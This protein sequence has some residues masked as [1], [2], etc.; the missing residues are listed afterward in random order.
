MTA[1][2]RRLAVLALV[3]ALLLAV[4]LGKGRRGDVASAAASASPASGAVTSVLARVMATPASAGEAPARPA[5]LPAAM[6]ERSALMQRMKADW[7]G[8]GAAEH[9][10]QTEGV[11]ER[12]QAKNGMVGTEAIEEAKQTPGAEVMEE[13]TGQVRR[14]WVRA[15]MQ[16]GDPR[17]LAVADFLGGLDEDAGAARV[18][19]QALARTTSDPMVTALALQRPCEGGGCR[20]VEASQWSRL[21]PANLQ[22]WLTLLRDAKGGASSSQVSYALDRMAAEGRYSRSYEREFRAVLLSLPQTE[23]PG[24]VNEAE[25]QLITG[26]AAAWA[27]ASY[28]P[29]TEACLAASASGLLRCETVLDRLWEGD[30]QMD[31]AIALGMARRL[32]LP[33]H[34]EQRARW[35]PRAREYE[36]VSAW[37][38]SALEKLVAKAESPCSP[39]TE[40]RRWI[41]GT[42]QLGEW[43]QWR[44]EMRAARV[45]DAA[46]SAQWRRDAGRSVLDPDP[47]RR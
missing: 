15:L 25:M 36:A 29:L 3:A 44:A 17:S 43:G 32:V 10:R 37:R 45:D 1:R 24:L 19:L 26:T 20:N 42:A 23:T 4:W 5:S 18:R 9:E 11:L 35:E 8:F 2:T 12:A 6:D 41:G 22:A 39:Q 21:E 46:L 34:P 16:R 30:N 33:V 13:A 40:M 47:A 27:I 38:N 28:K 14:R 31:R 7:C